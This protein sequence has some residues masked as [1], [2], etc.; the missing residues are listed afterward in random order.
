MALSTE[1]QQDISEVYQSVAQY[2]ATTGYPQ[3]Y[4]KTSN[5]ETSDLQKVL[6]NNRTKKKNKRTKLTDT[7]IDDLN[8]QIEYKTSEVETMKDQLLLMDLK[9]DG[10]DTIIKNI[11]K[12]I[13]PL[14]DEINASIDSTKT[15]YDNRITAGCKN[16]LYWELTS[17]VTYYQSYTSGG[18]G[19]YEVQTW[20]CKKNPDPNVRTDYPYYGVKYYRKPQ[21]QDYGANI[22]AEFLGTISLGSTSLA[23]V[24]AAE[25]FRFKIGDTIIDNIDSPT[26]F[27][28]TNLPSI[29]SFGTTSIIGVSTNFGGSISF[30]S[31]IIAHIG[32]GST[33][34]I[35]TGDAINLPGVLSPNTTVVGFNTTTIT[36]SNV[37]DPDGGGP[38]VG[39][40]I[41]TTGVTN[42]LIISIASIGSTSDGNFKVGLLTSYPSINLDTTSLESAENSNFTVVSNTQTSYTEFDYENNPIDPVTIGI[43]GVG[44]LAK[45]HKLVLVNNGKPIGPFQWN[46]VRGEEFAPEPK[47]GAGY[48]RYYPGDNSWP[49]KTTNTYD[50]EG[51]LLSSTISYAQQGDV[52]TVGLGNITSSS[53]GYIGV[54]ALNPGSGVCNPL[55]TAITTAETNRDDIISRNVPKIRNLIKSASALRSIRDKFEAQA[56]SILQ[57]RI[58]ADVELNNLR[59]NVKDLEATDFTQFE[60]EAYYFNSDTGKNSSST[61]GVGTV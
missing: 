29:V 1:A 6:D 21:N 16:N 43:M 34:G 39:S 48:A 50:S 24:G 35:N 12:E 57:G 9:I 38:G 32:I 31:T 10:Y 51:V 56:F 37:W 22:I 25:T 20:T 17:T 40:F 60:P 19:P 46:E 49:T 47:C 11:D 58:S 5:R 45:G 36:L 14:I 44:K 2:F 3:D 28:S 52:V 13:I 4:Y 8:Q 42:S 18:N 23:I 54:S 26:I 33:V 41:S 7:F 55:N 15:T 59:K 27:S 30:G 61:I 53:I